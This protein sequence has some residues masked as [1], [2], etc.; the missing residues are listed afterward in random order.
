MA[1]TQCPVR[2]RVYRDA[3]ATGHPDPTKLANTVMKFREKSIKLQKA[4]PTV[5]ITTDPPKPVE[6]VVAAKPKQKKVLHD[7]LRC[8]AL[9]LEGRRCGFK[10]VC[11][12]FCKKHAAV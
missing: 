2:N 3:V 5:K 6:T 10:S 1:E 4:R 11:G 12:E 8:K 9:T 7:A